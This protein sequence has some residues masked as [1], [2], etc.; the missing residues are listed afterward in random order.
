V[1]HLID[2]YR[3]VDTDLPLVIVG[4]NPYNPEYV[5]QLKGAADGRVLFVG[6]EYGEAFWELCANC[7]VYV[8]PSEVEGTSPVLLSAMGCGRCVVVN[9]IPENV[10]V[11]GEAGL[12]FHHNDADDLAGLLRELL[13]HPKWVNQLGASAKNACA[14]TTTGTR[15]PSSMKSCLV[16]CLRG[17]NSG[18]NALARSPA[19][20]AFD[21]EFGIPALI[22]NN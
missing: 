21:V 22:G 18:A 16:E 6:T 3:Q 12:A 17:S 9:G 10:D 14:S 19:G 2:A 7:Y 15:S 5:K 20:R 11:I 4:D 13:D 1:H 8:Q